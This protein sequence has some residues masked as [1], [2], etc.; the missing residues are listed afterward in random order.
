MG[1]F[2]LVFQGI[3]F[4]LR[5]QLQLH[6][7]HGPS[8]LSPLRIQYSSS[9]NIE[10][11]TWAQSITC[12][13]SKLQHLVLP[14]FLAP[15]YFPNFLLSSSSLMKKLPF[16]AFLGIFPG[17]L[18]AFYSHACENPPARENPTARVSLHLPAFRGAPTWLMIL[19]SP[20]AVRAPACHPP[21]SRQRHLLFSFPWG[22]VEQLRKNVNL[23]RE[24]LKSICF[25]ILTL[26]SL[27][28]RLKGYSLMLL[29]L[30]QRPPRWHFPAILEF[31]LRPTIC[32]VFS[33]WGVEGKEPHSRVCRANLRLCTP[34]TA[35]SGGCWCF[36]TEKKADPLN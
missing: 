3:C 27:W 23:G 4:V 17:G 7:F 9:W 16:L 11:K 14:F 8:H 2:L 29:P 13:L 26:H 30:R 1:E 28:Q 32:A 35:S 6:C 10:T 15:R 31:R 34:H 19:T 21:L 5:F 36:P 22:R 18:L 33:Q 12:R 25:E 24:E 20:D